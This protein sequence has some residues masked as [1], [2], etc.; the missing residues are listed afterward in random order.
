MVRITTT[1]ANIT[2]CNSTAVPW[3]AFRKNGDKYD[4]L[5][6]FCAAGND[7]I[8]AQVAWQPCLYPVK[9]ILMV[10]F[11]NGFSDES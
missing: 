2:R 8:P 6:G 3:H 5:D 10:A 1:T 4:Q 7:M 9:W 11:C